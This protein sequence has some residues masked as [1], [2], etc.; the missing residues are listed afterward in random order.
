[1]TSL[2]CVLGLS[3]GPLWVADSTLG[4][5]VSGPGALSQK[6]LQGASSEVDLYHLN[7][8]SSESFGQSLGGQSVVLAP[9]CREIFRALKS[10]LESRI[11]KILLD[12]NH[13][14]GLGM[15]YKKNH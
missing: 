9:V 10:L 12:P 13:E 6:Q 1:M 8:V 4:Q 14:E 2:L 5:T 11:P 15:I 3:L 7:L